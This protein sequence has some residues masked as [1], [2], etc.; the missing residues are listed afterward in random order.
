MT[1]KILQLV[2]SAF[3]GLPQPAT[4]VKEAVMYLGLTTIRALVLSVQVFSQFDQRAV[5]D[6][7]IEELARHCWMTG[8]AARRIAEAE[9]CDPKMDDQCFLA[10]LLHDVG[11]LIL[12]TGLPGAICRG[13]AIGPRIRPPGVGSGTGGIRRHPRRSRRVFAG[14]LGPSQPGR[15][16]CRPAPSARRRLLQRVL[17]RDRR[18]RRRRFCA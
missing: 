10:G 11:Q 9:H 12:A 15:R 18:P 8:L 16:S 13:S 1:T 6:F 14:A 17:A 3:F 5:K 4:N 7:S 2:N